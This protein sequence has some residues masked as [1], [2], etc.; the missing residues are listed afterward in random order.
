MVEI[1][2]IGDP[3]TGLSR[4]QT[5]GGSEWN[6]KA[7]V[8]PSPLAQVTGGRYYYG[9]IESLDFYNDWSGRWREE[10]DFFAV[11]P[12]PVISSEELAQLRVAPGF[13]NEFEFRRGG[14]GCDVFYATT[15]VFSDEQQKRVM[16][17]MKSLAAR[18]RDFPVPEY[19]NIIDPNLYS[20]QDEEEQQRRTG[21]IPTEV[22]VERVAH[23]EPGRWSLRA[24]LLSPIYDF[25]Y[26][27]H[28]GLYRTVDGVLNAALPMLARLRRPALMLPGMLQVVVKAQKIFLGPGGVYEGVWHHDGNGD[29]ERIVAVVLYYYRVDASMHSDRIGGNLEFFEKQAFD[30]SFWVGGD[31]S[32][33]GC[34]VDE[35]VEMIMSTPHCQVPVRVGS[36]VVFSNYQLIHRVLRMRNTTGKTLSRSFVALFIVDQRQP[37]HPSSA[38]P[39]AIRACVAS[40]SRYQR[41]LTRLMNQLTPHPAEGAGAFGIHDAVYSTGNGSVALLGWM[42]A[43]ANPSERITEMMDRF[44]TGGR[45]GLPLITA[46]NS[47][48]PVGRGVSWTLALRCPQISLNLQQLCWVVINANDLDLSSIPH[49]LCLEMDEF[50][51][52]NEFAAVL[53]RSVQARSTKKP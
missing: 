2:Q 39:S 8:Y 48:P 20:H 41:R 14:K 33:T 16:A 47:C 50:M 12:F 9:P 23:A 26:G 28:P 19:Q 49:D 15:P 10:N 7:P 30:S 45:D 51:L 21:W 44:P 32:P 38:Q 53:A 1:L 6:L 29:N 35:A 18:S 43:Q 25:D 22:L 34:Q 13:C 4:F 52:R 3:L 46:L 42:A 17:T 36:L 5:R 40:K 31:S 11:G 24:S 27:E 37:L